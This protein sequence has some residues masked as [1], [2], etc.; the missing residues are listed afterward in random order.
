VKICFSIVNKIHPQT[1]ILSPE[2]SI[3]CD[4]VFHGK[5]FTFFIDIIR[6]I[7]DN[8]IVKSELIEPYLKVK[9]NVI[10]ENGT[11]SISIENN[12]SNLVDLVTANQRI[13]TIQHRI[14]NPENSVY[15]KKEGGSGYIKINNIIKKVLKRDNYVLRLEQINDDRVFR[16]F[17]SFEIEGL[18]K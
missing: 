12:V 17:I 7:L 2:I 5:Y 18:I 8:I 10:E 1:P 9:L 4:V 14:D 15:L 3:D 13:A 16:S 6:N 11:L